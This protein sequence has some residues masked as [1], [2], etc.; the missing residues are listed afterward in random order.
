VREGFT[1]TL[2]NPVG[3]G[4]GSVNISAQKF[5]GEGAE[6]GSEVD[7]S[8]A[9]IGFGVIGGFVFLAIT[10]LRSTF[11]RYFLTGDPLVLAVA[12]M[13]IVTLGQWLNGGLYAVASITLFLI[14]SVT[15]PQEE[16]DE[17]ARGEVQEEAPERSPPV[18]V[19]AA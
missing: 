19:G 3:Q 1:G 9:F 15:R 7:I 10:T 14:G 2:T 17:V 16:P 11:R 4:T 5:G 6:T 12:G 8:N 13:L 18:P